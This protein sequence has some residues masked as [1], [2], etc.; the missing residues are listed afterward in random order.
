MG[1]IKFYKSIEDDDK[2]VVSHGEIDNDGYV[3]LEEHTSVDDSHLPRCRVNGDKVE[4]EIG[5]SESNHYIMWIALVSGDTVKMLKVTPSSN[6]CITFD[7]INDDTYIYSYCNLH[8]LWV[9]KVE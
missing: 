5:D 2:F 4:V 3:L 1:N 7:Y 8:G 9:S 6:P